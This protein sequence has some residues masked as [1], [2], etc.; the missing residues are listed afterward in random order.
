MPTGVLV[1]GHRSSGGPS[2]SP[3]S[4]LALEPGTRLVLPSPNGSRLL[5]LARR[6]G[7]SA[8]T[9][10]IR[11]C[12]AVE[13]E[14]VVG[15]VAAGERWPDGTL[16]FALEDWLGAGA[17]ASRLSGPRS[18][19]AVAAIAAWRAARTDLL[20]TLLATPSGQELVERGF[21]QDVELAAGIQ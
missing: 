20:S 4:L 19:E 5:A 2:L 16:R 14:G 21:R 10:C 15:I 17:V 1:A 7:C 9:A 11:D 6:L 8:R 3:A 18:P 12:A 13:D